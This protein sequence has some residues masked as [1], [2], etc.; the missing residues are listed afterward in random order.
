MRQYRKFLPLAAIV[1]TLA[2]AGCASRQPA[3]TAVVV[4]PPAQTTTVS[5]AA[6]AIRTG[7]VVSVV[8][9][10]TA[11]TSQR[12]GSSGGTVTSGA[13]SAGQVVT[14]QFDDG[15]R[16]TY[17][18][19]AGGQQFRVGERVTVNATQNPAVIAR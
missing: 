12:M 11:T 19:A 8:D 14:V 1:A 4:V 2:V 5:Q 18:L 16:Q 7:T 15:Q 6:P 9:L 10:S 17:D 3:S 13:A